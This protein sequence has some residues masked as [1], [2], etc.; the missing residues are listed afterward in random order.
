M[1]WG[2]GSEIFSSERDEKERFSNLKW[3]C[4]VLDYLN[5]FL[6]APKPSSLDELSLCVWLFA[7]NKLSIKPVFFAALHSAQ[8]T[9]RPHP[10]SLCWLLGKP[11]KGQ[12]VPKWC[13]EIAGWPLQTAAQLLSPHALS[14][15]NRN[16][17]TDK[18]TK[19]CSETIASWQT[20]HSLFS[21]S[22]L[23]SLI[24]LSLRL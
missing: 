7:P 17:K 11:P 19:W 20:C 1:A 4:L 23:T 14:S 12:T 2:A 3:H 16:T 9:F 10:L 13:A 24:F 21:G 5:S 8:W 6:H 22:W 18:T 15:K